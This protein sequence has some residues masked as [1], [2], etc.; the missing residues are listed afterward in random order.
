MSFLE[1]AFYFSVAS[2]AVIATAL[3]TSRAALERLVG[4]GMLPRAFLS[5]L[6]TIQKSTRVLALLLI[7]GGMLKLAAD[8]GFITAELFKKYGIAVFLIVLGVCLLVTNR[9]QTAG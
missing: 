3:L 6:P 4:A 5:L 7:A 2:A 1:L 8:L 9:R